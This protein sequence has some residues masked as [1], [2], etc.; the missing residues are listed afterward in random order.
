MEKYKSD[1][2]AQGTMAATGSFEKFNSASRSAM[3]VSQIS[4]NC[5]PEHPELP[6]CLNGYELQ[7]ANYTT[8]IKMPA[9][10]TSSSCFFSLKKIMVLWLF[11]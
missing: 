2:R 10:A 11:F 6:F 5:A 8:S 3:L 7:L 1:V 4:Q 9:Y